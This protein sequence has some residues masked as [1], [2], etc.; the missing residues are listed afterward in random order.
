MCGGV[1]FLQTLRRDVRVNLG[2][3]QARVTEQFLHAAQ[4][5]TGVEQMR[6]MHP[7]PGPR[8]GT[9]G[10]EFEVTDP[11]PDQRRAPH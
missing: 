7:P 2:R 11:D 1:G 9:N 8:V 10:A 4:V 6:R 3:G 5:R